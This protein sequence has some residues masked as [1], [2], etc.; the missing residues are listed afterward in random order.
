MTASLPDPQLPPVEDHPTIVP[1]HNFIPQAPD[2]ITPSPPSPY[3]DITQ[4][5]PPVKDPPPKEKP[6]LTN[7]KLNFFSTLM[8][9]IG[10]LFMIGAL[11][12]SFT[13]LAKSNLN[14][15]VNQT[16]KTSPAEIL[17]IGEISNQERIQAIRRTLENVPQNPTQI[18]C[19]CQS[20]G[21]ELKSGVITDCS[22]PIFSWSGEQTQELNTKIVGF[23]VY[24]GQNNNDQPISLNSPIDLFLQVIRPIH[25]GSF[26]TQ[27]S[28]APQNL[29]KGQ[30]YYLA[31]SSVSDSKN[32]SWKYGLDIVDKEKLAARSA[33]ILFVYDY[34]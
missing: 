6:T 4:T 3:V 28:F 7:D 18:S 14:P 19:L 17:T 22:D 2:P 1:N 26:Q 34:Q 9:I 12:Y 31:V 8:I 15:G 24:F 23:Y 27:N 29:I 33:K 10:P 32:P 21:Q 16:K 20:T 30:K 11:Y 25:D 5:S 13:I